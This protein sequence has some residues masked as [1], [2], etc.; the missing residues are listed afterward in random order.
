MLYIQH[1][2]DHE[3]WLF[4][5]VH[6]AEGCVTAVPRRQVEPLDKEVE[7]LQII[8]LCQALK[9]PLRI[10][11]LDR[12][13]GPVNHHDFPGPQPHTPSLTP[14]ASNNT[15]SSASITSQPHIAYHESRITYQI[16]R[17]PYQISRIPYHVSHIT[18]HV[19]RINHVSRI[20]SQAHAHNAPSALNH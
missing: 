15:S 5:G 4:P 6:C 12:S 8:A 10:E 16:S 1:P 7:Q 18:Y 20:P 17:I 11:Y 2:L 19:S 9:V 3:H 14:P 13:E